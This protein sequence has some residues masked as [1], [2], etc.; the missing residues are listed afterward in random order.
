M[1]K[2]GFYNIDK[3]EE[4]SLIELNYLPRIPLNLL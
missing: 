4:V 1:I 3:E 2:N